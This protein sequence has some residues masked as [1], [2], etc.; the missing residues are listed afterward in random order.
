MTSVYIYKAVGLE[1]RKPDLTLEEKELEATNIDLK[2]LLK[3]PDAS[4]LEKLA[5]LNKETISIIKEQ[6]EEFKKQKSILLQ[7]LERAEIDL[8]LAHRHESML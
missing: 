3:D 4:R 6:I 7:S 8:D 5:A 2:K 1:K